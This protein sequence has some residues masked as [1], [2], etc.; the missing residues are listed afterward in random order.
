MTARLTLA[1]RSTS[2][3]ILSGP[4]D[5]FKDHR[6]GLGLA[7]FYSAVHIAYVR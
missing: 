6:I 5:P 4:P 7:P 2:V 1:Y 3:Y